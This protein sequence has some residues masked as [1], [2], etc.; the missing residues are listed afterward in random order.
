LFKMEMATKPTRAMPIA[1]NVR[2]C[3]VTY[4]K[5]GTRGSSE[6]GKTEMLTR[7]KTDARDSNVPGSVSMTICSSLNSCGNDGSICDQPSRKGSNRGFGCGHAS[8]RIVA[9]R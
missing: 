9:A 7:G 6:S 2:G 8:P 1:A 5:E 3:I 4:R